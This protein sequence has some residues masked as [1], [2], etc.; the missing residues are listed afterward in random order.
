MGGMSVQLWQDGL[1]ALLAAVGLASIFWT[2]ARAIL[3]A[4]PE[5][6]REVAALLPAQGDGERLEE[7]LRVLQALRREQGLF[8]RT[9]L[10]DCG[11][12]EEG[13]RLAEAL[14]RERRWV[15]LCGKDEV[16]SYLPGR[17][18]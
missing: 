5:R 1:V 18:P 16:G 15:V 7:Q 10:V 17:D 13:R 14:A 8:G 9:L 3:F 2:A 12:S 11:L 6:R 4:G